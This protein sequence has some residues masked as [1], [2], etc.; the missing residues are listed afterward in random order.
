MTTTPEGS[1]DLLRRVERLEARLGA[2]LEVPRLRITGPRGKAV[3]E[4]GASPDGEPEIVLLDALGRDRI[5]LRLVENECTLEFLAEDG[6]PQF[7]AA[8]GED[9]TRVVL[10]TEGDP[11]RR[12]ELRVGADGTA[13]VAIVEGREGVRALFG[14][15]AAGDAV[16][17][18]DPA[19]R[20]GR[21]GSGEQS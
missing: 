16:V 1:P 20:A 9:S 5:L 10:W 2:V 13:C 17:R 14:V 11:P 18:C 21:A 8:G 7:R 4:M 6:R 3:I 12:A 19:G 15:N